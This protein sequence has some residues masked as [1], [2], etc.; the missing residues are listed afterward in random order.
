[1]RLSGEEA[2]RRRQ[3]RAGQS[4]CM[5]RRLRV[6][7]RGQAVGTRWRSALAP[8]CSI[9]GPPWARAA[10]SQLPGHSRPAGCTHGSVGRL[11]LFVAA[12]LACTPSPAAHCP[13][14]VLQGTGRAGGEQWPVCE[15]AAPAGSDEHGGGRLPAGV[16]VCVCGCWRWG[17]RGH[18]LQPHLLVLSACPCSRH[19]Y[20][21][22][23]PTGIGS[24][25]LAGLGQCGARWQARQQLGSMPVA[26]P[27]PATPTHPLPATP[28]LIP[29]P[30]PLNPTPSL[31]S[32]TGLTLVR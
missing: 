5:R 11:A 6:V 12:R 23:Q 25:G 13:L 29:H 28:T 19:L 32:R 27:L 2:A 21:S 10:A 18:P 4:G 16:C 14:L 7:Q 26:Y 9:Q 3:G 20:T 15:A 8:A 22:T 24:L 17:A 30:S 1:M 31:P